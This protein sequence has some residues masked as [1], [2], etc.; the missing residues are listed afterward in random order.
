MKLQKLGDHW[1]A[2]IK[3]GHANICV[4]ER[5]RIKALALLFKVLAVR[6]WEQSA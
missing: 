2:T 6:A 3:I 1:V 4:F 5:T